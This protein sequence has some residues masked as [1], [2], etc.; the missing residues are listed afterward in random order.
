MHALEFPKYANMVS[1]YAADGELYVGMEFK[2]REAVIQEIKNYDISKS[3]NYFY[4]KCKHYGWR[5]NWLGKVSLKK[6]KD[7]WEIRKYN[8]LHTCTMMIIFQDHM[9]LDADMIAQLIKPMVQANTSIKVKLVIAEIQSQY[10]Y[11]TTYRKAWMAKQRQL[12]EFT[13]ARSTHMQFYPTG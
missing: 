3:V 10:G 12:K 2:D 6:K 9:K 4:C 11:M 5:C 13:M 1:D 8:G 7:I